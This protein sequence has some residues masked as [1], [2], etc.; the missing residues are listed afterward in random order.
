MA[1]LN[2]KVVEM[3]FQ[4]DYLGQRM[5]SRMYLFGRTL[6][7]YTNA[8]LLEELADYMVRE[9]YF[10]WKYTK[11]LSITNI[12]TNLEMQVI[13]P[14]KSHWS[15]FFTLSATINGQCICGNQPPQATCLLKLHSSNWT[16]RS[17]WYQLSPVPRFDQ[18]LSPSR[19]EYLTR[20]E[21]L[22]QFIS[23]GF[24]TFPGNIWRWCFR[25]KDGTYRIVDQGT[26]QL[27][28]SAMPSRKPRV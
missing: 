19:E 24:T 18:F 22:M 1:E 8:E 26:V 20:A 9:D 3:R 5:W 13:Y 7:S 15:I 27:F 14:E 23:A 16:I 10:F 17:H 11:L 4:F 12:L 21:D 6:P 2:D 28:T 25:T